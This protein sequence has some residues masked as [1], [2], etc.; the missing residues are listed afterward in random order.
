MIK[1]YDID[2]MLTAQYLTDTFIISYAAY[3]MRHIL[4]PIH[5][6]LWYMG[7]VI[8]MGHILCAI[9]YKPFT[10][11][12]IIWNWFSIR[13]KALSRTHLMIPIHTMKAL[14]KIQVRSQEQTMI[15][16]LLASIRKLLKLNHIL[17]YKVT[18]TYHWKALF[19]AII[20]D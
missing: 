17:V 3:S 1:R 15:W 7:H 20:I 8:C 16:Y 10:M 5:N 12:H 13:N 9:Y 2:L 6:Y 11:S 18:R 4:L 14:R 19:K